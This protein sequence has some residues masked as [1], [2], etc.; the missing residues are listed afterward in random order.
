MLVVGGSWV[1]A[2]AVLRPE[3]SPKVKIENRAHNKG[4]WNGDLRSLTFHM[5]LFQVENIKLQG[6]I[7]K[8]IMVKMA[9][10][11]TVN[12]L[13]SDEERLSNSAKSYSIAS[14]L[15]RQ[16]SVPGFG[17]VCEHILSLAISVRELQ[18]DC[19]FSLAGLSTGCCEHLYSNLP[20]R[21]GHSDRF[22]VG[23]QL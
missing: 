6:S 10:I 7:M 22:S 4:K 3:L 16:D 8:L 1:R 11:I 19:I 14:K 23:A 18:P 2:T 13:F 12:L 17:Q 15:R 5:C 9:T 20:Q 21:Q